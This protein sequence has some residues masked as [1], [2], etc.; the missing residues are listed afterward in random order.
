MEAFNP[1]VIPNLWYVNLYISQLELSKSNVSSVYYVSMRS[2]RTQR[3]HINSNFVC[4]FPAREDAC[5]VVFIC[6]PVGG[7]LFV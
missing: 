2:V 4:H 6:E 1:K 5:K 7:K 3:A